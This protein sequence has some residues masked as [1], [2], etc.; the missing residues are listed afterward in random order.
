MLQSLEI[1]FASLYIIFHQ[2]IYR[3]Y[4]LIEGML[5]SSEICFASLYEP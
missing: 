5:Q 1:C 3:L 4:S 2:N